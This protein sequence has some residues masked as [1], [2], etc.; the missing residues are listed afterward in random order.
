MRR[1]RRAMLVNV[2]SDDIENVPP[3]VLGEVER[4]CAALPE[5][6]HV[7]DA[8]SHSFR[9]RRTNL[10]VLTSFADP[11]GTVTTVLSVR[12]DAGDAEALVAS[13]HPWFATGQPNRVGMIID[14]ATD[15]DE[16]AAL[17]VDAYRADAPKK[18]VAM[19]N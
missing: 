7:A 11:N 5:I 2:R 14:V 12:A 19:L 13:G 18:L 8:W 10:V 6:S 4:I 3:A 15:W 17:V 9:I 1:Y 16:V